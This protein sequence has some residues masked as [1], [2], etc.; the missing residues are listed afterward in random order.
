MNQIHSRKS[1]GFIS[2]LF[3]ALMLSCTPEVPIYTVN[4]SFPKIEPEYSEIT[5]PPNIAPL[6]FKI[7]EKA[8][9][10]LVKLD[11]RQGYSILTKSGDGQVVIPIKKWKK[12]LELSKGKDINLDV[13]AK[14]GSQWTKF[15]TITNHVSGDSI[16]NHLVYRLISP[17]FELWHKMGIY[18]RNLE[19][20]DEEPIMVSE[21]S[22]NSCMNCHSFWKNKSNTMMFHMRGKLG[23]T[24]I[25]RNGQSIL[26]NTKTDQTLSSAVYPSWHPNGRYIAFSVNQIIQEFHAVPNKKIEV[27]D[28]SSDLII[29]DTEK[30]VILKSK[31]ISTKEN[32]ETFPCWSP[33]G[34]YLYFCSARA[35][36]QDKYDQIR[37]DLQ[38]ISF[39]PLTTQFGEI[40]TI[41]S[42]TGTG[43]SVSFPRIS[44]DGK[45]LM[46][47]MSD[48]GNFSI[49]H[50]ESDLFLINLE[51]RDVT[52]LDINSDQ[53]ESYHQWSSNGRWIVFSSRRRNGQF[54]RLYFSYFSKDGIAQKPFILPQKTPDFYEG[55][56]KSYNIP[57]LV[58]SKVDL[59]PRKLYEIARTKPV[60]VTVE[61]I[62]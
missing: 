21:M 54:T 60:N 34:L 52:K 23:G 26:L 10:Y 44:P 31:K 45:F 24:I 57:E 11:S 42:S 35:L 41:V 13:Y 39:N 7:N 53:S 30:N 58:T 37:Y 17:G 16:D 22:D 40:D 12:L 4:N 5:I 55:F 8:D 50:K 27:L 61:N 20:F 3:G 48:Y 18:Q 29:F 36:T 25:S 47:C 32:F 51:S 38:R 56:M 2:V 46:F 15:K 62:N 19:N 6:N 49:W 28:T 59:D 33:D 43:K 14:N 9:G 1:I